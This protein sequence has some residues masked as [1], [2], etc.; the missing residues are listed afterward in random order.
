MLYFL[1]LPRWNH[2]LL[3]IYRSPEGA[4]YCERL[5]RRVKGSQSHLRDVVKM[6]ERH[7]LIRIEPTSKVKKLTL[8]EKG[9]KVALHL[10]EVR[11]EI[12]EVPGSINNWAKPRSR[13]GILERE[14]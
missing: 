14:G 8:T 10:L 7:R 13:N 3:E 9:R 5:T 11:A 4:R 6:L 12:S 1:R 2:V